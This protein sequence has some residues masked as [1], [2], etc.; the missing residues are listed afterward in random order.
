[1][2]RIGLIYEDDAI[3][4]AFEILA[5]KLLPPP[6]EIV[7]LDGES[8]PA[9][10]GLTP[11]LLAVLAVQHLTTPLDCVFIMFDSNSAPPGSRVARIQDKIGNRTYPFGEPHIHAIV[12]QVETWVMGDQAAVNQAAGRNLPAFR[13]PETFLD[14]KRHLIQ[15]LRNER[16]R[17]PYDRSFL[18]GTL[19][20]A[21]PN[22]IGQN[23]PDFRVF[24]AKLEECQNRQLPLAAV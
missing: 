9:I 19:E 8:W 12:R 22:T 10:V 1:V 5:N 14:P 11:N 6:V 2:P 4:I 3:R 21:N 18:R 15:V 17:P 20:T 13:N 7:P 16:A 23:C 24:R